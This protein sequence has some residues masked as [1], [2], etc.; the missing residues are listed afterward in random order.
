MKN[1]NE[2]FQNE[3][4]KRI[5]CHVIFD[6]FDEKFQNEFKKNYLL[7]QEYKKRVFLPNFSR[8][9]FHYVSIISIQNFKTK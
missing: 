5:T 6:N 1:F 2:K 4:S 7:K 8:S 9:I 3:F